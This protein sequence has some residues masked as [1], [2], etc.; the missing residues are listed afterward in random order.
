MIDLVVSGRD[1]LDKRLISFQWLHTCAYI[2][3]YKYYMLC[4][5]LHNIK[6]YCNTVETVYKCKRQFMHDSKG[7]K[8]NR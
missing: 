1:G 6:R 2:Q 5:K 4:G 8:A 3:D 7:Q